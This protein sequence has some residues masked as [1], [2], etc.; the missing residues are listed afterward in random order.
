MAFLIRWL[1]GG[2]VL[3]RAIN[4]DSAIRLSEKIYVF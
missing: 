2:P 1:I 3:T 4:G